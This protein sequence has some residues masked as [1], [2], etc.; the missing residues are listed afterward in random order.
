MNMNVSKTNGVKL[1]AAVM[2]MAMVVAG[3]AVVI[4][5][6][7]TDAFYSN[8]SGDSIITLSSDVTE[9][10]EGYTFVQSTGTLTLDGYNGTKGFYYAGALKIIVKGS[11]SITVDTQA[12]AGSNN[13]DGTRFAAIATGSGKAINIDGDNSDD[14]ADKLTITVN[15]V[16]STATNNGG[17]EWSYGIL[18]G[19]ALTIDNLE[20]DVDVGIND[21]FAFAIAA[22]GASTFTNVT[23]SVDGGNRAVQVG[24]YTFALYGCELTFT[25]GEKAIQ[26]NNA[27]S[28]VLITSNDKTHS[29]IVAKLNGSYGGP[30]SGNNDGFG[31]KATKLQIDANNTLTAD[32][33]RVYSTGSAN[34]AATINGS[35][36]INDYSYAFS[37]D[38]NV[39]GY[40]PGF[41]MDADS[42]TTIGS[43]GKVVNNSTIVSKGA[44]TN[45]GNL[46]NNGAMVL[47][48][49]SFENNGTTT[50]NPVLNQGVEITGSNKDDVSVAV[51]DSGDN[52]GLKGTL[53]SDYTV[54]D[55]NYLSDDLVIAEGV[56][57]TISSRGSLDLGTHTL[58]VNGTLLVERNGVITAYGGGVINLSRTGS[59]ENSGIIGSNSPVAVGVDGG[60]GQVKMNN[61][62]GVS[63]DL[64]RSGSAPSYTYTLGV[65]GDVGRASGTTAADE[66]VLSINGA[67]VN[68]NLTTSR[69]VTLNGTFSV[70]RNGVVTTNGPMA[71]TATL[72]NG[73]EF[74]VAGAFTGTIN[75]QTNEAIASDNTNPTYENATFTSTN[76]DDVTVTNFTVSVSRVQYSNEGAVYFHQRAYLSGNIGLT[77]TSTN[78]AG[79]LT[80]S[81]NTF[82]ASGET[83]VLANKVTLST[84]GS[85]YLI[86]EGTIQNIADYSDVNYV[87]AFYTVTPEGQANGV[88]YI[89]NFDAA[90]SAIATAD[91]TTITVSGLAGFETEITG[92]YALDMDEIVQAK[93]GSAPLLVI[94]EAGV[95]TVNDG[96]VLEN[97]AIKDIEGMVV[98][99]YGGDCTPDGTKYDVQ[100]TNEDGDITYAGLQVVLNNAQPGDEI[101]IDGTT[102]IA[103]VNVPNGVK[104]TVNG[105]LDVERSV[106]IAEGGELIVTGTVTIGDAE[107]SIVGTL[108]VA[109]TADV[110]E[111]TLT[112][113]GG[114]ADKPSTITS[115]G[116]FICTSTQSFGSN[117]NMSGAYYDGDDGRVVT[118]VSKAIA[119]AIDAENYTVTVIGTVNDTTDV[120]LGGVTLVISAGANATLGNIDVQSSNVYTQGT[121]VLTATL[122]GQSGIDGSTTQSAVQLTA[123]KIAGVTNTSSINTQNE[124]VWTFTLGAVTDGSVAVTQGTVVVGNMTGVTAADNVEDTLTVASGATMVVNTTGVTISGYGSVEVAGT[125]DITSK[126]GLTVTATKLDAFVI[127]GTVNVEGTL[128]VDYVTVTGTLNVV[129]NDTVSGRMT[130]GDIISVGEASETLGATGTISGDVALDSAYVLAYPGTT[131]AATNFGDEKSVI[132]TEFYI[133][134]ALYVTAYTTT[135]NNVVAIGGTTPNTGFMNGVEIVGFVTKDIINVPEKWFSDEAMET[136]LPAGAFNVGKEEA[137]YIQLAPA[138]AEIKYSVG[139]GISLYVDGIKVD[140]SSVAVPISVGT[141]TVTATFNPGYAGEVTITF[142]GQTITGGTFEVTPEMAKTGATAVVLSATGNITVDTGSTGSSDGMG[143]TEILLVIL[144]ILIVVMAIM[145]ALRLM[146]S[147]RS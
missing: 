36:T 66:K 87:G 19:G 116:S 84:P 48:S 99:I 109:G 139:T 121:G 64:V 102:E 10:D 44:L 13:T 122:V 78:A 124:N 34:G 126:G 6:S 29:N 32:G 1:L 72:Q 28:E 17:S 96:A 77:S 7:E 89:T 4:S 43:T 31:V 37:S 120:V 23:G 57:L 108:S 71:G 145:V 63:F 67:I 49:G 81:G 59:I 136:S 53:L 70:A 54:P 25:G 3:A 100:S 22:N 12:V 45:G 73:A 85:S 60:V 91:A 8:Y 62:T 55:A 117:C 5:D 27:N 135:G 30:Q 115:T 137:V 18:S 133:N 51:S 142:N 129:E 42:T 107:E 146:R 125:V 93:S 80:V 123:A 15:G 94:D 127:S 101:T 2:V 140:S 61:V 83:V 143:L 138:N 147:L 11:N 90:M 113:Y 106:T 74:S 33:I 76:T 114:T 104:L 50:G 26:A 82:V 46:A 119:E 103:S 141:H 111:G 97:A 95:I 16:T 118:T 105:T 65:S 9:N 24:S 56:T 58:T 128:G 14:V 92:S 40:T 47:A 41:T 88:G 21:K 144:V 98:V 20:I 75:A 131:V 39:D 79:T 130:V 86:V 134:G 52:L 132:F 112:M 69:D 35:V 38:V 68:G 110:T